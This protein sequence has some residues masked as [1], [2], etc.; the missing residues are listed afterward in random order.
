MNS[1]VLVLTSSRAD[2][3]IYRP[4]LK[5]LEADD[6][7][8]LQL[9]VFGSHLYKSH[10]YTV[11]EIKSE[12]YKIAKEFDHPL[13]SDDPSGISKNM[14]ALIQMF[15]DY[16]KD[17]FDNQIFI[18]LGD[19]FEM[20]AAVTSLIP[21]NA[22]IIHLHGGET[23]L[24]AIDNIFR[25]AISLASKHHF[26]ATKEFAKRLNS[27]LDS[28]KNVYVTGALSLDNIAEIELYSK[29]EFEDLFSLDIK[30]NT[31]LCTFHPETVD[32]KKNQGFITEFKKLLV[33]HSG[34][35]FLMGL[36]NADTNGNYLREEYLKLEK[37]FSNLQT[38]EH[39]GSKGYFSAINLC[40][41]VFGNSSSGIIEVASFRK[42]VVN[43]GD[44]QKGRI[45]SD[46]TINVSIDY[47]DMSN[48]L[49]KI[50]KSGS[51]EGINKYANPSGGSV[52]DLMHNIILEEIV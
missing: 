26:C 48:A 49:D 9:I 29:R 27:L 20:F 13:D 15:S 19:R 12:G 23:T 24:G 25:H 40:D 16:L 4:L 7:I 44:R 45:C 34:H 51:Y 38:F 41:V 6:R 21:F 5:K 39:L 52:S 1:K 47:E 42:Y 30:E 36:P 43:V 33:N 8:D 17:E 50:A 35:H 11:N 32:L 14:G 22:N 28:D 3:G 18:S 2:F 10:G 31:V 37:N 46:N